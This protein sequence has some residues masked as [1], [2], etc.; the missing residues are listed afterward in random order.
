MAVSV[1]VV[2]AALLASLSLVAMDAMTGYVGASTSGS[3]NSTLLQTDD[4]A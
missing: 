1:V 3:V 2:I 4:M